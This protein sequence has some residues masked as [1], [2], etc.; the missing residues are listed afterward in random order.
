VIP[1][2]PEKLISLEKPAVAAAGAAP[3]AVSGTALLEYTR[4]E[5][6]KTTIVDESKCE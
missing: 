5:K 6:I 2:F 1:L 3:W 4:N